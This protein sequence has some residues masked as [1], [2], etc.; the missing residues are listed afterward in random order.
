MPSKAS[1]G[2]AFFS[3]QSLANSSKCLVKLNSSRQMSGFNLNTVLMARSR[4]VNSS[5][6]RSLEGLQK[7]DLCGC[8]CG[9]QRTVLIVVPQDVIHCVFWD[10]IS[11]WTEMTIELGW[12]S[13][14]LL[15]FH[16]W[17]HKG[18]P[19]HSAS[20]YGSW[21]SNPY[22]NSCIINILPTELSPLPH[23]SA[24]HSICLHHGEAV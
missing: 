1:F 2:S 20:L 4:N 11:D 21:G 18:M 9:G 14:E 23:K 6:R 5:L 3:L 7:T 16:H 17:D 22:L 12:L 10:S 24:L 8:L 13:S 19:Q 15:P